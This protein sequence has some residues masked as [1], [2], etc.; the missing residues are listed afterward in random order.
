MGKLANA[1][2]TIPAPEHP[3]PEKETKAKLNQRRLQ[4]WWARELCHT[5]AETTP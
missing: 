2:G 4:N 5:H 1:S 3:V